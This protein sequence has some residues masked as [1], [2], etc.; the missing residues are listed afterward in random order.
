[1]LSDFWTNYCLQFDDSNNSGLAKTQSNPELC[2][3]DVMEAESCEM[4]L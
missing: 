4:T 3:S 2:L 1:M